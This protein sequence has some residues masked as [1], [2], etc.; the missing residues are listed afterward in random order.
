MCSVECVCVRVCSVDCMWCE[1]LRVVCSVEVVVCVHVDINMGNQISWLITYI[2]NV[3]DNQNNS[4][5]KMSGYC[6][7]Y[8]Q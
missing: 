5:H 7:L 4:Q 6:W 1:G 3:E 8:W 2:N